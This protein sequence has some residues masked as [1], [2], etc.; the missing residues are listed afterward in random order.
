MKA[1]MLTTLLWAITVHAEKPDVLII[2][3]D[4]FGVNEASAFGQQKVQ[5][6]NI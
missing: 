5:T 4:S 3:T 1:L 2:L 6:P